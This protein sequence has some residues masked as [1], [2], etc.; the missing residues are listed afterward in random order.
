[1]GYRPGENR[2]PEELVDFQ[3]S[4]SPSLRLL[5]CRKS[6]KGSRRPG[7]MTK[8]LLTKLKGKHTKWKQG[9]ATQEGH[10]DIDREFR[11]GVRKTKVYLDLNLTRH[12]KSFYKYVSSE[13]KVRENMGLMLNEVWVLVTKGMERS[14]CSM[15][16]SPQP[17]S[18]RLATG[19]DA[20]PGHLAAVFFL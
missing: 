14:R 13:R 9:Q 17:L 10:R 11:D 12:V 16:S 8:K 20:R 5:M 7:W 6:N 4:L 2:G 19:N 3:R 1:M 15:S 18:V